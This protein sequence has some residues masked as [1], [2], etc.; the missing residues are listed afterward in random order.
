M[1]VTSPS[2]YLWMFARVV[3]THVSS[4]RLQVGCAALVVEAS[5]DEPPGCAESRRDPLIVPTDK[6]GGTF[7]L[8]IAELERECPLV[9]A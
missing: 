4:L 8:W 6:L 1:G 7:E 5:S 3:P 9:A 2:A